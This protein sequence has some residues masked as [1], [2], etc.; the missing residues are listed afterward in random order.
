MIRPLVM[1]S[2]SIDIILNYFFLKL[3]YLKDIRKEKR[4]LK[5]TD[6]DFRNKTG[7]FLLKNVH[8]VT[9]YER[10]I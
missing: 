7:F 6:T 5:A 8:N 2:F 9:A 4:F 3:P 1:N 10:F